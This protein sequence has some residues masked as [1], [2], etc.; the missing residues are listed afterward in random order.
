MFKGFDWNVAFL[1]HC[2]CKI[3]TCSP[4]YFPTDP[5]STDGIVRLTATETSSEAVFCDHLVGTC[6]CRFKLYK[7]LPWTGEAHLVKLYNLFYNSVLA[8]GKGL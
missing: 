1:G 8:T 5:N 7:C 2:V 4:F 6:Y 3:V